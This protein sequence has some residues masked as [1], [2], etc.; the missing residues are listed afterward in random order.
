MTESM[1]VLSIL[2]LAA[3]TATSIPAQK[4]Q[5]PL[6]AKVISSAQETVPDTGGVETVETPPA[7]RRQFPDAP[8]SST[9]RIQ[10]E[11][12]VATKVE[13]GDRIYILQGGAL[14]EPGEYPADID[15]AKRTARLLLKDKNGKAKV[16]KLYVRSVAAKP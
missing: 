1:R 7:V 9:R 15:V 12:Y 16:L 5:F 11:A 10:P 8:K 6:T 13:I 2:A 3:L 14:V 4:N